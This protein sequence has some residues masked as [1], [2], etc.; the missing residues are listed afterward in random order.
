MRDSGK[1]MTKEAKQDFIKYW[2]N[3]GKEYTNKLKNT[4]Q[5]TG[6]GLATEAIAAGLGEGFEEVAEEVLADFSKSC[7]NIWQWL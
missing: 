1:T 2:F 4:V 7:F 3:K 5:G 6:S